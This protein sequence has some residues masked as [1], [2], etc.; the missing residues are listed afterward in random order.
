MFDL[1]KNEVKK[2]CETCAGTIVF[3]LCFSC[4]KTNPA[5]WNWMLGDEW[6]TNCKFL[7]SSNYPKSNCCCRFPPRHD[8]ERIE[9][10]L[11]FLRW[12]GEWHLHPDF[13]K[14]D[15]KSVPPSIMTDP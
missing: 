14:K 15:K 13:K 5:E 12:C 3:D 6:C 10:G 2:T 11:P 8:R 9:V 4:D 7:V 1:K